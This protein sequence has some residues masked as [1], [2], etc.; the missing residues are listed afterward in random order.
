[1]ILTAVPGVSARSRVWP[2]AISPTT[3]RCTG[4]SAVAL[5]DVADGTAYPSIAGVVE[6]RQRIGATTSSATGRPIASIS[7]CWKSGIGSISARI[8][9]R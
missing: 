3:G 9:S 6:D 1:M 8:R 2:A 5:G 4:R 7:G